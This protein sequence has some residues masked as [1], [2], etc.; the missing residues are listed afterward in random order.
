[1]W[2]LRPLT[3]CSTKAYGKLRTHIVGAVVL[4]FRR[5]YTG[6]LQEHSV[7]YGQQPLIALHLFLGSAHGELAVIRCREPAARLAPLVENAESYR[8]HPEDRYKLWPSGLDRA[9]Y[10]TVITE[11]KPAYHAGL[12]LWESW[13]VGAYHYC[14]SRVRTWLMRDG[15]RNAHERSVALDS[16][17]RELLALEVF[18]IDE[19]END[20][21]LIQALDSR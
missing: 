8:N 17:L 9:G 19:D 10:E 7:V 12:F 15:E 2:W 16:V 11:Y 4:R 6:C 18:D 13:M 1:M 20:Q 3:L 21:Q 5:V 14:S